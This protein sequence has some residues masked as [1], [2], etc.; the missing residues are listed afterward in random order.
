MVG[1]ASLAAGLVVA[2]VAVGLPALVAY[3]VAK[4]EKPKHVLLRKLGKEGTAE[5]RRYSPS[6]VAEVEVPA[7]EAAGLQKAMNKGFRSVAG[8]VCCVCRG[9]P[10]HAF[11]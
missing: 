11:A 10:K 5:L 9:A 2:A 4:L 6:T 8:C 1:N 7:D 3:E